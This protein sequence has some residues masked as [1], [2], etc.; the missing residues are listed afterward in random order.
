MQG[1]PSWRIEVVLSYVLKQSTNL[2][3]PQKF[4]EKPQDT[5][6]K[7]GVDNNTI[8]LSWS[9]SPWC[10][11]RM[12]ASAATLLTTPQMRSSFIL[13]EDLMEIRTPATKNTRQV[14]S[15]RSFKNGKTEP[16][17]TVLASQ[18]P[19]TTVTEKN[20]YWLPGIL[21]MCQSKWYT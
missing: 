16:K 19:E 1:A 8:D 9:R 7:K 10:D 6:K 15:Q 20:I 12:A 5:V 18:K 3:R 13:S 17:P 14:R 2:K 4:Q 11:T 21:R